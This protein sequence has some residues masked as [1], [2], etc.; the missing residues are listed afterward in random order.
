LSLPATEFCVQTGFIGSALCWSAL[1]DIQDHNG[2]PK[3]M[4][5]SSSMSLFTFKINL[6]V[7]QDRDLAS[8]QVSPAVA[9]GDVDYEPGWCSARRVGCR[10]SSDRGWLSPSHTP[11][12]TTFWG[13]IEVFHGLAVR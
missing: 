1:V 8:V 10:S 11:S 13:V 4:C 5:N 9:D 12:F 2:H 6:L 3:V 7:D